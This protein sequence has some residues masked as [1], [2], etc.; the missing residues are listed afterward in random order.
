MALL[1]ARSSIRDMPPEIWK[2]PFT[3]RAYEADASGCLSLSGLCDWLQEAAG[4]HAT[5]LGVATD[6]LLEE[7]RAWVLSRLR[8]RVQRLPQWRE[9]LFIETWPSAENGIVAERDFLL[10]TSGGD[11]I[12][13]AISHWVVID[14]ERRRPVRLPAGVVDLRLPERERVLATPLA[15]VPSPGDVAVSHRLSVRRGDLDLN[16][17]VNNSRYVTWAVETVPAHLLETHVCSGVDVQ[18][19]AEGVH[20][21]DL[22]VVSGAPEQAGE[23]THVRHAVTRLRDGS[24]LAVVATAW[25]PPA[26]PRP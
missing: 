9:E 16:R 19:R 2:E 14:V 20:G 4:N 8:V 26:G 11:E 17:H 23:E 15:T 5:A 7:R 3:V 21:D 24:P 1:S 18:F 10:R 25:R 6:R 13:R 12:A 22:A